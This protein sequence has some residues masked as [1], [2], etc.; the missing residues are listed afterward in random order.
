MRIF[1]SL[2][3]RSI[4]TGLALASLLIWFGPAY[5]Q[6]PDHGDTPVYISY[7]R[8][9][10]SGQVPWRDIGI[11][12]PPLALPTFLI[13]YLFARTPEG[14]LIAFM[15]MMAVINAGL[16]MTTVAAVA[17]AGGGRREQLGAGALIAAAPVLIGA[18]TAVSRYDLW[19]TLLVAIALL[20]MLRGNT[21]WSAGAL[22]AGAAAKIWP[23]L[24]LLPVLALAYRR[25]GRPELTRAAAMAVIFGGLPFAIAFAIGG[26]G[27]IDSFEYHL[28]RP[29]QIESLGSVLLVSMWRFA[30]IG[31]PLQDE[32]SFGS[33][34]P[35]GPGVTLMTGISEVLSLSL[36]LI[37][38]FL[39]ARRV[40][41][42]GN[43]DQATRAAIRFGFAAVLALVAF[44]KVMSPQFL[45]WLLPLPFL[46]T[47]KRWLIAG[48]IL[49][50]IGLTGVLF[51]DYYRFVKEMEPLWTA[52]FLF[53]NLV[54]AGLALWMVFAAQR[55]RARAF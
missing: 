52:I 46:L 48:V 2:S 21:R 41:S 45:L 49:A 10:F 32:V 22:G 42:V 43:D 9:I 24:M 38:S 54:L 28:R 25:G 13:P 31:G 11:E 5:A 23:G 30:G 51:L 8:A 12:Y 37:A 50:A 40:I 15:A 35:E 18:G 47:G 19:P 1:T 3:T 29:L 27:F 17:E 39:G 44:G 33:F 14:Y 7:A 36:I 20:A 16:I 6:L 4:G 26:D 53:R 34:N 55:R